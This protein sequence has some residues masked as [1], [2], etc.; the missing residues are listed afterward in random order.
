MAGR[1]GRRETSDQHQ[2]QPAK[3]NADGSYTYVVGPED[4]GVA[5]WLDT[6]G[7]HDG[8]ILLRWQQLPTGATGD[9]LLRDFKVVSLD[10]KTLV[11]LPPE[12]PHQRQ[13]ALAGRSARY[14]ERMAP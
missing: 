9:G 4:P 6:A 2:H 1:A 12:T 8:Y 5:N 11:G 10:R 7:L 3:P 14:A 13:G